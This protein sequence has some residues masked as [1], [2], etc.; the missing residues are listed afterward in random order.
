MPDEFIDPESDFVNDKNSYEEIVVIQIRET[1]KVLSQD[2]TRIIVTNKKTGNSYAEDRRKV[3]IQHI[4]TLNRLLNP[5]M[6]EKEKKEINKIKQEIKKYTDD[7]GE[8]KKLVTGK[9]YVKYKYLIHDTSSIPYNELMEFKIE[10]F[11]EI[12][13]LLVG[14][15]KGNKDEIAAF[16]V[17]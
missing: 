14:Y 10:M 4:K 11:E 9:G 7:Y 3:A 13:G 2:L 16:S 1:A 6:K 12:F 5:F 15:Y 17:E 8:Q